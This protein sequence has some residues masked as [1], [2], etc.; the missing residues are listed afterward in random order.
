MTVADIYWPYVA[1]AV[2]A[3]ATLPVLYFLFQR[4]WTWLAL[5]VALANL[6][7]VFIT[8][9]API[10]GALDP[11]YVGYGYGFLQ[12]DKGLEVTLLAGS[13]VLASA[14]SAWLA[15]RNRPGP[16]M[17]IVA[18]TAAFHLVNAGFPLLDG[19]RADPHSIKI[20][21]G[22]YLTVPHTV[23][24]P[25]IIALMILPFLLALPWALQRAFETE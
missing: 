25:A 2:G 14:L 10:R 9:A 15:I 20:Q 6:V 8:G 22:E 7:I 3:A 4:R 16:L 5:L 19:I 13:V 12:A 17:L 11:N 1:F 21:F 24:I 23:A 18:A